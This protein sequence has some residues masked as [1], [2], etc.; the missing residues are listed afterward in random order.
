MLH[1]APL[2]S[3]HLLRGSGAELLRCRCKTVMDC[4]CLSCA[5]KPEEDYED[6]QIVQA[7]RE[8]K[9]N[10]GDLKL[11]SDKDYIVPKHL[12]M[13]AEKKRAQLMNLEEH[14]HKHMNFF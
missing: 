13:N 2:K 3:I 9:E 12:R 7:I 11:K 10:I 6:P 1:S 5:E 4:W 8:A 14:V